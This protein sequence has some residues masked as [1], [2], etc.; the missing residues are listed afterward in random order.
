MSSKKN[1]MPIQHKSASTKA[2][3]LNANDSRSDID[4]TPPPPPI[5]LQ[6][7]MKGTICS[8]ASYGAFVDLGNNLSGLVHISEIS[9]SFVKDISEHLQVGQEVGVRVISMDSRT[10]RIGLS[11]KQSSSRRVDGYNRIVELGGDWGH[12]WGDGS[13]SAFMD[14]GPRPAPEPYPW[15]PDMRL[16]RRFDDVND[17]NQDS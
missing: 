12:P 1:G 4:P 15:E 6:D 16:F 10:G 3:S 2:S 14:L 8:I 9:H 7:E 5:R 11:I 13:D 17:K